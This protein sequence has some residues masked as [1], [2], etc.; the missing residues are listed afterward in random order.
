M[1]LQ[2]IGKAFAAAIFVVGAATISTA[3]NGS[4]SPAW[5]VENDTTP[6]QPAKS[7]DDSIPESSIVDEVIWVVGDEPILKSDVEV[8]RM[9][10]EMEGEKIDGDPEFRVPEQLAIQKLFL[11]QA[12]LDSVEVTESEVTSGVERQLNS[13]IQAVGSRE[14]LEE[15]RGQS[16]TAIREGLRTDYRN[17]LLIQEERKKIV[18]DIAVTPA[19]VRRYFAKLPADSLPYVPTEV[20]VQI[21]MQHPKI[22]QEEINRV[23]DQLREFT[24]RINKGETTFATLARLYSEDGSARQGGELGYMGRGILDPAFA[25]VAFN[26]TDPKK[27]SK[28][29]ESEFGFHIIQLIDKRGDKVNVRHILLKPKV[30]QEAIDTTLHTLDSIRGDIE[31]GKFSFDEACSYLSDDKDTRN[32]HGL[33][34][35]DDME[36]QQRTS[37][38]QMKDLPTEV[39]REVEGLEVDSISEPFQMIDKN[40]KTACAIIKLK[41]RREGHR[42]DIKEDYQVMK[43][44]VLNKMR[45]DKIKEWIQNKINHTYIWMAD[46]YRSG[47]YEY[48][49][50]VKK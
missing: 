33:M 12:E 9:Q 17:Q 10:M 26:L 11:H 23:K 45:E 18:G 13:W 34:A 48:K 49:G 8:A 22:S 14:K 25:Q 20:E 5:T 28:I 4:I 37:R 16:I 30:S 6:T 41:S 2:T 50:W 39:A 46:R 21:L 42:A 24:D 35:F 32:N 40:G 3:T 15:Y 19:D 36:N 38:F 43:N 44:V 47:D 29:V 27:V 1:K 31:R 7:T